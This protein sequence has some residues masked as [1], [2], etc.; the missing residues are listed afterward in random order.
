MDGIIDDLRQ[1]LVVT[2]NEYCKYLRGRKIVI[3]TLLM[4]LILGLLTF[5]VFWFDPAV[6]DIVVAYVGS[7]ALFILLAATLFSSSALVAEFEE[8]TALIL[9]TR[10]IRKWAIFTGKFLA[11]FTLTSAYLAV[12]YLVVF[13]V[14]AVK[15]EGLYPG[16]LESFGLS[17]CYGL[18]STGIAMFLSAFLKKAS[19]ASM[20]TFFALL[21]L[22][23]LITGVLSLA[24]VE[25]T[26][27]MVDVASNSILLE[28]FNPYGSDLNAARDAAV[29]IAWGVA[30]L[31]ASFLIFR[32]R[33]F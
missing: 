19:T 33:D 31:G 21:L 17:V 20:L 11:A 4:A 8:R 26:W 23:S 2:K 10:P 24:G 13:V 30:S 9:F 14:L 5:I 22:I 29:M 28:V 6:E 25:D 32:K 16:L 27:F 18:S 15:G 12:Y 7:M 3:F 1:S